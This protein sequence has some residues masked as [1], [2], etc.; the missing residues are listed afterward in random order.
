MTETLAPKA[1]RTEL[2]GRAE[3]LLPVLAGRA[4]EAECLR[5]IPDATVADLQDTGLIRIANPEAFGGH[6]L[7]YDT[8]IEVVGVLG[9]ACGSTAWCYSVWASHNWIVGMYPI[10]A[11]EEYFA[12]S[13]D[14]LSSSAFA[15]ANHYLEPAD[16]G[17]HLAGRWSFSSGADTANWAMIG[18][19]HPE[20]GPGL[21][22][23]P[24]SDYRI[25][26]NWFVSGLKGTGSKDL[27]I[28]PPAFVPPHR[29]LSFARMIAGDTPGRQ[30]HDRPTYRVSMYTVLS[31][32]LVWPLIGMADGA[33]REFERQLVGRTNIMGQSLA[34]SPSIQVLLAESAIDVACAY[35]LAR[36]DLAFVI[37]RGRR[38]EPLTG[39]EIARTRAH[40][41]YLARLAVRAT[42]RLFEVS[43]GHGLFETSAIQ[44]FHRDVNAGSHQA[45]LTWHTNA[46][47]YARRRLAVV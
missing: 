28:D 43:G 41:A 1:T 27:V 7:D 23:I 21:C 17:F 9:R 26:D 47:E 5:R 2:L 8:V 34:E 29:F 25:D 4:Q 37:E 22:L 46:E 19:N 33:S 13:P 31:H 20:Q 36:Q 38:E 44:R 18:A 11:Q 16:A 35:A 3:D 14:E 42:N 24:R 32:T 10:Q 12:T 39:I 30:I 40:Q 6:G 15:A 45:A